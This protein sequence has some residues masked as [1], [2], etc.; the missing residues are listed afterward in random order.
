MYALMH[1]L[2]HLSA[3]CLKTLSDPIAVHTSILIWRSGDAELSGN[4]SKAEPR[5]AFEIEQ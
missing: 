3:C 2:T 4:E 5:H 1:V